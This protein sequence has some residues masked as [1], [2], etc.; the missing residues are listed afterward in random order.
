[1]LMRYIKLTL[2]YCIHEPKIPCTTNN[3]N[4]YSAY[5]RTLPHDRQAHT[6]SGSVLPPI[7]QGTSGG[8]LLHVYHMITIIIYTVEM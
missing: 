5:N 8:P 6:V 3:D 2:L 7:R 4:W 1:M